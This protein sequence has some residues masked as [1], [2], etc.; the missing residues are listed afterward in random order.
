MSPIAAAQS[1]SDAQS[2]GLKRK[3]SASAAR[4]AGSSKVYR[5]QGI[6]LGCNRKDVRQLLGQLLDLE[7][8]ASIVRIRSLAISPNLK[9]KTAIID[10]L[11]TPHTLV[12]ERSEWNFTVPDN[13]R[14]RKEDEEN[15]D[16]LAPKSPHITVDTHFRGL[17]VLRSFGE[18]SD[19]VVDCVAVT[20]LGGHA[21]GSFKER[22]GPHMWLCDALPHDLP[23]ARIVLWGYD[24]RTSRSTS[25]QD[26]EALGTRLR[27]ALKMLNQKQSKPL[28]FVAHSLGGLIFKEAVIQMKRDNDQ[29]KLLNYIYGA[30]FFGVPSQ[31]MDITSLIP[32]VKEQPNQALIHSLG[33]ES[34]LL[35]NQR[36]DFPKAFDY[37][38]SEIFYFYETVMSPTAILVSVRYT[39]LWAP[40]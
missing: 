28:I 32:M 1:S 10:F 23:G 6:P 15:N 26:F 27:S 39:M 17:T 35:R 8:D 4:E 37:S 5:V 38:D 21:F 11:A 16:D 20:G 25:F 24:S 31:G 13:H 29:Q 7:T 30:L 9:T 19:H 36:R 18:E 2:R 3:R 34:Q 22:G 12:S 14:E 33:K 40:Y